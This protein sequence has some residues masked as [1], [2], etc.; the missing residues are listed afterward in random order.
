MLMKPRDVSLVHCFT[1]LIAER[2][3]GLMAAEDEEDG[4]QVQQEISAPDEAMEDS[5]METLTPK[6]FVDMI[7]REGE[8]VFYAYL[9]HFNRQLK[10]QISSY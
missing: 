2:L 1:C 5:K 6:E 8:Q 3:V 7:A 10:K 9:F 4:Q